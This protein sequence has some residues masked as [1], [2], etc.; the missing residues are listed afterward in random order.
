MIKI[1]ATPEGLPAIESALAE[2]IAVNVTLMFSMAHYEAVADAWLRG[3]ERRLAT[4]EEIR[5]SASVAS[6]FVSRVDT[7]ADAAL[8]DAAPALRGRVAIAN[9]RRVFARFREILSGH[10]FRKLAERGARPQRLLW[11]STST[12]DPALPDTLYVDSLV[13][14]D[15]VNTV[16]QETWEAVLAHGS[17]E[18]TV[19][20][21]PAGDERVLREA[22]AA[23]LDLDRMGE[24]L[25]REG[26]D[27]FLASHEAL[28]AAIAR[29]RKVVVPA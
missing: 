6:F 8:K 29:R 26:V 12:K 28:V 11:A 4:G 2:G 15:T 5:A 13:G 18:R 21:D 20:R 24:A 7:K 14:P 3:L 25:S 23:G 10:R 22:A 17:A 19:D 1:P 27:K 9:S 16:P